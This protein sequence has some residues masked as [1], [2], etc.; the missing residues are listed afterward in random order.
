MKS[1]LSSFAGGS[2]DLH[3]DEGDVIKVGNS[4]ELNVL[5]TPGHTDGKKSG[6]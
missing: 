3:I 5:A 2:A 4:V 1:V 6:N